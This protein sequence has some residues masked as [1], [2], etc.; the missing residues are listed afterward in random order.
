M[1]PC[2]STLLAVLGALVLASC[3]STSERAPEPSPAAA[4]REGLPP[5]E[6]EDV[7]AGR[8][9]H[10][11][12]VRVERAG[13]YGY[14]PLP[15]P[16]AKD[17]AKLEIPPLDFEVK[18]PERVT[19]ENG[20]TLYL[21]ADRTVPI[22]S[23]NALVFGGGA[24]E[25]AEKLG[26]ADFAFGLLASG[27]AGKRSAEELDE[28]L[29]F[30]AANAGGGSGVELSSFGLNLRSQDLPTLFPVF[31][32]MLLRPRYQKDRFEVAIARSIEA[33][34]RRPDSPDGL[35]ARALAKAI[36][37]KDSPFAREPTERTLKAIT[38]A[39]LKAFRER[40]VTPA[41]T[42]FLVSGDF[43][44]EALLK[45]F[46]QQFGGWKGGPRLARRF[47]PAGK[48]ERRVIFVPKELAQT[49]L[50]IG[51]HGFQRLDPD[52]FA[53]RVMN[54]ALGGGLGAGRLYREI[55][56]AKGLAYSAYSVAAP[57]PTVGMFY[58]GADTQPPRTAQ[59]LEAMLATLDE[60]RGAKA[61]TVPEVSV[62]SDM[63]LNAFAFR[64]DSASKIVNEK[65]VFDLFNYPDDYLDTFRENVARVDAEAVAKAANRLLDP[66]SFQIV[67]VGPRSLEKELARFGPVTVIE[68]VEAFR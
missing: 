66:A 52:E 46:R 50:R 37:G 1:S 27:G 53:I 14:F 22:V 15:E 7:I 49:K 16:L 8:I 6:A 41:S 40:L 60:V 29:E 26:L 67:V 34:R 48:L 25:P 24:E 23:V 58:A 64:F 33:V 20:I 30:H 56:E 44:R 39:D 28:L 35:A 2:R 36:H 5:V 21:L 9:G 11:P 43:D 17:P 51:G 12:T 13:P 62:A 65:A 61:L 32:D 59:A 45:L 55:R 31:A 63:Y 18:R 42:T 10:D 38:V 68:D 3:A 4:G 54:T 19:L 57:G 47:P